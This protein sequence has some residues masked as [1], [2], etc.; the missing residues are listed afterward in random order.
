VIEDELK[1]TGENIVIKTRKGYK[2][3]QV[4]ESDTTTSKLENLK[5]RG[6]SKKDKDKKDKDKKEDKESKKKA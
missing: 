2:R 6:L 4:Y 5:N 1:K 3:L